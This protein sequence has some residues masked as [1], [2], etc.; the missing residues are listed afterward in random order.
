M[1]RKDAELVEVLL[2]NGAAICCTPD[3]RFLLRDGNYKQAKNLTPADSL[4]A[5][6]FDSAPVR[7]ERSNDYLRILQPDG[8]WTFVHWLADEYNLKNG[9]YQR[10]A[11]RIRHH[12]NFTR[13][14]MTVERYETITPEL[15]DTQRPGN[16]VPRYEKAIQYFDSPQEL[17]GLATPRN[18]RVTSVRYLEK[19]EDVYD[20]TVDE[21]HNFLLDSGVFA[22]NSVD[23]DSPAAMRYTEARLEELSEVMLEDIDK[24][25]VPFMPNFDETLLEPTLLP[26]KVPNLLINGSSGIAVG[27]AT[28]IP[29]HHLG[30]VVDAIIKVID[31][32]EAT[33]KDLLKII[34][35]PDFPSGATICGR[36][37]IIEAYRSGRGKIKIR[38]NASIETQKNGREFIVV[39]EIPYQVNKANLISAIAALVQEKKIDCIS[40]IRDESDKEGMRIVVEL[41]RG[42]NA[43]VVLNQLYAHTQMEDTFGIIMLALL[44]NRPQV[45][46]L[47]QILVAYIDHRKNIIIHRTSYD[48]NKAQARAHILEGFKIAISQLDAIIK[49]IRSAKNPP[50]AKEQLIAKFK[51]TPAQAQAILEMQLQRLTA[52]EREKLEAEYLELIKKIEFYRAILASEQKVLHII[53]DEVIDLK[54][55]FG[56]ARRT[57]IVGDVEQIDIEDLIAEEDMVITVSHTGY[58]KRQP[59]SAYRRQNR[60]GKGVTAAEAKEEDFLEDLFIASTHEYILFFTDRGRLHWLKV[61]DMPEAGR[62]AKGKPMINVLQLEPGEK[63]SAFIPVKEF[64]GRYLVMCTRQGTIKKTELKAFSNPRRGGI[65]AITLEKGDELIEA[66]LTDGHRELFLATRKGIAVR[67]PEAQVRG[68]G[69]VSK[70]VRGIRLEKGDEVIAMQVV[71]PDTTVLTVTADGVGKRTKV[72]EYRLIRRGGKGVINIKIADKHNEVVGVKAVTDEDEIMAMT[73]AGMAVRCA[74]KGIRESGRNTQGVRIIRLEEKDHVTA[75]ARVVVA[76][77]EDVPKIQSPELVKG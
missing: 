26:A 76:K 43:Q 24:E 74:V 33:I 16:W 64:D 55:R 13:F 11:G 10:Q 51:L 48:L 63:I 20:I 28:N 60:G 8:K 59:V 39:T 30:E 40:D 7:E 15:F 2:D 72:A 29:P 58:I 56:D 27:M 34:K 35:G 66:A 17:V 36:D 61:Y 23:G 50:E 37:G 22:H 67:F 75:I 38:A 69:R 45:L 18:H 62:Y 53:K 47:K 32:P 1:T 19:K 73:Q 21:Y 42:E 54:K 25:T 71:Q 5:G 65:I 9:Q 41:K 70:G 49:T 31:E 4:M 3:H 44:D 68:M 46:N 12:K 14:N 57:E 77:E 52:L 6:Y